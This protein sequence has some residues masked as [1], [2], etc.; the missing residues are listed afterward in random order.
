MIRGFS[1][2]LL[3]KNVVNV[4][5]LRPVSIVPVCALSF[6]AKEQASAVVKPHRTIPGD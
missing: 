5:W 1:A 4:I 2:T 6:S 3:H